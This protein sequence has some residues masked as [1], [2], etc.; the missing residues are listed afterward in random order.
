MGM[1]QVLE[2]GVKI[3]TV[4]YPGRDT[5]EENDGCRDDLAGSPAEEP[6]GTGR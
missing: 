3:E 6:E 2:K 1:V 4:D 5:A